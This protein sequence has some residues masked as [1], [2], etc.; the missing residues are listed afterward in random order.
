MRRE[1]F[2]VWLSGFIDGEGTIGITKRKPQFQNRTYYHTYRAYL[3]I[4]ST[5]KMVMKFIKTHLEKYVAL[6][7]GCIGTYQQ[8][9]EKHNSFTLLSVSKFEH[10]ISVL[11][12]IEPY[13]IIK[14]EQSKIVMSFVNSR[15]QKRNLKH[16]GSDITAK[17]IL[18]YDRAKQLN[19]KGGNEN[20]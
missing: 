17:E 19:R 4:V 12:E 5:N 15:I 2:F 11:Q 6:N 8:K 3:S 1:L 10:L 14:R 7:I 20:E 16:K 9:N 13:L 18:L